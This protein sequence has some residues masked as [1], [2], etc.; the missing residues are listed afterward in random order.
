ME[1]PYPGG[2]TFVRQS[3]IRRDVP[4][5]GLDPMLASLAPNTFNQYN[6]YYKKWWS[7]CNKLHK[8]PYNYSLELI[9]SFLTNEYKNG[10]SYATL[11]SQ[12]ASL[13]LI[14]NADHTDKAYLKRFLKGVYKKH[15]P[16]PKYQ[17][18]WNPAP[19]LNY[20][21]SFHPPS[22]ITICELTHKL[23][24][25]LA[26]IIGHRIQTLSKIKVQNIINYDNKLEIRI[27]DLI[28]T[29]DR[30]N[31]QPLLTVPY[32]HENPKLC[33][34]SVLKAY[35]DR[36]AE[37]RPEGTEYLIL[38]YNKPIHPASTQRISG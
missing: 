28:K 8:N 34:A 31:F 36:T 38:T 18:T 30:K 15:P 32:F 37:I 10:A 4:E 2:R 16:K 7:F 9:L 13:S 19:V 11:N 24:T 27:P 12:H 29:S 14:F 5:I 1:A 3:F 21:S 20:L 23:V 33:L 26:L 6:A 17:T 35:I 25:L 22:E